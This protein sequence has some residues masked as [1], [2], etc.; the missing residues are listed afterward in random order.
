MAR[1]PISRHRSAL[2]ISTNGQGTCIDLLQLGEGRLKIKLSDVTENQSL[3]ASVS[4]DAADDRRRS[5][6]RIITC[7]RGEMHDEDIGALRELDEPWVGPGLIGAEYDRHIA[8][9]YAVRRR[10]RLKRLF[11]KFLRDALDFVHHAQEVAAP[12]FFD[13]LFRVAAADEF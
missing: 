13:L 1:P 3:N 5:V 11:L 4:G 9:L 10:R 2:E 6:K 8:R 12:E 7:G